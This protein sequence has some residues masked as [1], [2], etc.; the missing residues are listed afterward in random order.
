MRFSCRVT[1]DGGYG[2]EDGM[3]ATLVI[4]SKGLPVLDEMGGNPMIGSKGPPMLDEMGGTPVIGSKG[5]PV[6]DKMGGTPVTVGSRTTPV[7]GGSGAGPMGTSLVM[8]GM[9]AGPIGAVTVMGEVLGDVECGAGTARTELVTQVSR[10]E[11]L[12]N[13]GNRAYP[14]LELEA[15]NSSEAFESWMLVEAP[16]KVFR[17]RWSSPTYGRLLPA[18]INSQEANAHLQEVLI[19]KPAVFDLTKLLICRSSELPQAREWLSMIGISAI[20]T[21][22]NQ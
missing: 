13:E 10:K 5:P 11:I 15:S 6:V 14:C 4:G 3:G 2:P 18:P 17:G 9:G 16:V 22:T 7:L 1:R 12:G 21:A 19:L 20:R 8:G